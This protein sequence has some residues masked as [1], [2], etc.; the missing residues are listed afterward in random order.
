MKLTLTADEMLGR[1]RLLALLEPLEGEADMV[2][3]DGTDIDRLLEM[4]IRARYLALL[5]EGDPSLTVARDITE[6]VTLDVG[7]GGS[8]VIDLPADCRCVRE[9]RLSGW[10]RA[11]RPLAATDGEAR[12]RLRHVANPFL[13]GSSGSPWAVAEEGRLRVWAPEGARVE[14]LVAVMEPPA[15]V[16]EL[17][18]RAI[19]LIA[20]CITDIFD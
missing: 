18:E 16:Y 5:D 20:D 10:N 15:G 19:P 3:E 17:D 12:R 11:V 1:C 6:R 4:M 7:A 13:R 8:G 9:V 2:R 14:R